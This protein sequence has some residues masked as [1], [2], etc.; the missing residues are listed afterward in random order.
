[1]GSVAFDLRVSFPTPVLFADDTVL[2]NEI[3]KVT[4]KDLYL[5][6]LAPSS[7]EVFLQ[8]PYDHL[9][10]V[11]NCGVLVDAGTHGGHI[12]PRHCG[13]LVKIIKNEN[14]YRI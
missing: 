10:L 14:S 2:L 11:R 8:P 6:L 13:I 5:L 3:C 7:D 1:M 4:L 9:T 12:P